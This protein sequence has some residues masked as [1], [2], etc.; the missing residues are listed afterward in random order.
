MNATHTLAKI[1]EPVQISM[2]FTIARVQSGSREKTVKLTLM[3]A[4][5]HPV[6]IT[7]NAWTEL[8]PLL[9]SVSQ[10]FQGN[11]AIDR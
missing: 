8:M 5:R 6:K 10:G 7:L 9:V 4:R 3:T 1:M 11:A 2:D